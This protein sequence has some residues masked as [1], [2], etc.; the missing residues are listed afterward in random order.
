[1]K[2]FNDLPARVDV[3]ASKGLAPEAFGNGIE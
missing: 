2:C 1:M 3:A